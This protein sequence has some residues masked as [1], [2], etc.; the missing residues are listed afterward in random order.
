MG[1]NSS[2][3]SD[4]FSPRNPSSKHS[5]LVVRD[6]TFD[7]DLSGIQYLKAHEIPQ[8]F[9]DL[10]ARLLTERPLDSL[11]FIRNILIH[12][13]I[14]QQDHKHRIEATLRSTEH[15]ITP[16]PHDGSVSASPPTKRHKASS[17]KHR[18]PHRRVHS[19]KFHPVCSSNLPSFDIIEHGD[20]RYDADKLLESRTTKRMRS[21]SDSAIL[22]DEIN[23]YKTP[24]S[25]DDIH[26]NALSQPICINIAN[27][28]HP[29]KKPVTKKKMAFNIKDMNKKHS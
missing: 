21:Y 28:D 6:H 8:L 24:Y 9:Q 22:F 5:D 29:R 27:T 14:H 3:A 25:T 18:E 23:T 13:V 17:N 26:I 2:T 11:R 1:S 15:S 16:I 10:T 12:K 4:K 20:S 7:Y 19:D